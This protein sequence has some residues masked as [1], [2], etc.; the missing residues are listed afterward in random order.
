MTTLS[1]HDNNVNIKTIIIETAK[2]F[3][4]ENAKQILI[5]IAPFLHENATTSWGWPPKLWPNMR[6]VFCESSFMGNYLESDFKTL[7]EYASSHQTIVY[8]TDLGFSMKDAMSIYNYYLK[9]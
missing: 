2:I 9:C 6:L 7:N 5:N 3:G 8:L 1:A 4:D